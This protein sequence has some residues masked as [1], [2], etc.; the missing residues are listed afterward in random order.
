MNNNILT[1]TLVYNDGSIKFKD[2]G[3]Y[4]RSYKINGVAI[5][6]ILCL[7]SEDGSDNI[8][9]YRLIYKNKEEDLKKIKNFFFFYKKALKNVNIDFSTILLDEKVSNFL[10]FLDIDPSVEA[11]LIGTYNWIGE[12]P[13]L[14]PGDKYLISVYKNN[15]IVYCEIL[16]RSSLGTDVLELEFDIKE[17]DLTLNLSETFPDLIYGFTPYYLGR[18]CWD[19]KNSLSENN[20]ESFN[21]NKY[22]E[23]NLVHNYTKS[24]KYIV[25]IEG[26]CEGLGQVPYNCT[27]CLSAKGIKFFGKCFSYCKDFVSFPDDFFYSISKQKELNGCFQG[28]RIT[29]IP[30]KLF[31]NNNY[32]TKIVS[33]FSECFLLDDTKIEGTLFKGNLFEPLKNLEELIS[34]F[35][36]CYYITK[37]PNGIFKHNPKLKNIDRCFALCGLDATNYKNNINNKEALHNSIPDKIVDNRNIKKTE[38][39]FS[40]LGLGRLQRHVDDKDNP[41]EVSLQ[42]AYCASNKY[43][44]YPQILSN[45]G[46]GI[47]NSIEN[48]DNSFSYGLEIGGTGNGSKYCYARLFSE[49]E[50]PTGNTSYN[51]CVDLG[52]KRLGVYINDYCS[53]NTY[54]NVYAGLLVSRT[55]YN[56][57]CVEI[58]GSPLSLSKKAVEDYHAVQYKQLKDELNSIREWT[59]DKIISAEL[60][61]VEIQGEWDPVK[62]SPDYKTWKNGDCYIVNWNSS[63]V[64]PV[65]ISGIEWFKGD[66]AIAVGTNPENP[67]SSSSVK[68][69]KYGGNG[70]FTKIFSNIGDETAYLSST[71]NVLIDGREVFKLS[72]SEGV[73]LKDKSG[74]GINIFNGKIEVLGNT[75]LVLSSE[76]VNNLDAV[77]KGYLDRKIS[78]IKIEDTFN[79]EEFKT[80]DHIGGK[81]GPWSGRNYF[82][83]D[84]RIGSFNFVTDTN[85]AS[86]TSDSKNLNISFNTSTGGESL[87]LSDTDKKKEFTGLSVTT[88][89]TS[90]FLSNEF[91]PLSYIIDSILP[92][93]SIIIRSSSDEISNLTNTKWKNLGEY[94]KFKG[95]NL[96][97]YLR[98]E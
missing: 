4:F 63:D 67:E 29:R 87:I 11:N 49:E 2:T 97:I 89:K 41:H 94:S 74:I 66:F 70:T 69:V 15:N 3:A 37:I 59:S 32:I 85:E 88:D 36:S 10:I 77:T 71:K 9:P 75:P 92:I 39:V 26:I 18:I 33:L 93:G 46:I 5:E 25:R 24:G 16:A 57:Y 78:E 35:D 30:D 43:L 61:N 54:C 73:L 6:N 80:F 84:T 96:Y 38:T 48:N 22:G 79:S 52:L 45:R 62:N 68:I 64:E 58:K 23:E 47:L 13:N 19:Y 98:T 60:D 14:I 76:P 56:N 55:G 7:T 31:P 17:E 34:V 83:G 1:S 21:G 95:Y 8:S 40:G 91:V 53:N 86:I 82:T 51:F 81:Y 27:R 90:N 20:F 42:Q 65:I 12:V 72:N 44:E 28:T 50:S